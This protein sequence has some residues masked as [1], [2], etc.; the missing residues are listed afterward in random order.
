MP[1]LNN[2]EI[3]KLNRGITSKEADSVINNLLTKKNH[4]N[5]DLILPNI[6]VKN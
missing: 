2:K 4:R 1:R 3:E 5:E 6:S